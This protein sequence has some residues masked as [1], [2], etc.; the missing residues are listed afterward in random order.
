MHSRKYLHAEDF[1]FVHGT[2]AGSLDELFPAWSPTDRVVVVAP[3]PGRDLGATA[4]LLLALTRR[5]YEHPAARRPGF[6]DYPSHFVVGGQAGAEPHL[7][8]PREQASWSEAWCEIDVWPN[9][10]H[11]VAD[12]SPEAL[13]QAVFMLEPT[14]LIWPAEIPVPGNYAPPENAVNPDQRDMRGIL[15]NRL[16]QVLLWTREGHPDGWRVE[17]SGSSRQ[18]VARAVA[19]LPAEIRPPGDDTGSAVY[20]SVPIAE[21]L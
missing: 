4:A 11:A 19:L 20:R 2:E 14:R 10:H 15:G 3:A 12:P 7:L 16:R 8:S 18:L 5:Y 9:T 17:M 1:A 13:L 21:F 6:Y